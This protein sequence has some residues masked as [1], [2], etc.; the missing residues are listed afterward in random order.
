MRLRVAVVGLIGAILLTSCSDRPPR[1]ETATT[2]F[3]PPPSMTTTTP[4]ARDEMRLAELAVVNFWS[5][6]D[7]LAWDPGRPIQFLSTV[8]SGQALARW[9][10]LTT[11]MR[12]VGVRQTGAVFFLSAIARYDTKADVYRVAACIDVS[13]VNMTDKHGTSL[14]PEDREPW[15]EYTYVVAKVDG[16]LVVTEDSNDGVPC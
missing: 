8:A 16:V 15:M 10:Q 13:R 14:I 4:S 11:E 1:P 6:L 7:A 3:A 12:A 5:E 2:T 9:H